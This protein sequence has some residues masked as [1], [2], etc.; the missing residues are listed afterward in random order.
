[1]DGCELAA[2]MR[3]SPAL[4]HLPFIV[5]TIGLFLLSQANQ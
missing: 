1:M 2:A 4:R 5:L 3:S